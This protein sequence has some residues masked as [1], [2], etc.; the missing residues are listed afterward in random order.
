[1]GCVGEGEGV[2]WGVVGKEVADGGVLV[3][4]LGVMLDW[5]GWCKW[6]A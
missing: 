4:G 3:Q 2:G 6:P 5:R 1:M